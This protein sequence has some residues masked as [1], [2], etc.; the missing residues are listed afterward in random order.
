MLCSVFSVQTAMIASFAK[1]SSLFLVVDTVLVHGGA[2]LIED[3]SFGAGGL[4]R[5]TACC[6]CG[7]ELLQ[8][9]AYGLDVVG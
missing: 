8:A 1:S 9:F 5:G 6:C 4:V 2:K 7:V 3:G